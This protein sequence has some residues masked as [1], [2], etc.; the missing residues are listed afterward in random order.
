VPTLFSRKPAPAPAEETS[1]AAARPKG[2]TPSKKDLGHSTP[3]RTPYGKATAVKPANK[4]EAV[5]QLRTKQREARLKA[6]EDMLAGKEEALLPRDKG[7]ER[8]L[9]RNIVDARRNLGGYLMI[10][11]LLFFVAS[12]SRSPV[13]MNYAYLLW[14][15]YALVSV[16]D[17][18]LIARRI[19]AILPQRLPKST[20]R[21]WR[22]YFYGGMRA[23]TPRRM[24]MPAPQVKLGDKV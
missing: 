14:L 7:P 12:F 13:I 19:K 21:R 11:T 15:A 4:K 18:F 22:L 24:R 16:I 8:R 1:E 20:V 9:V 17:S 2:Y 6:R 5:R 3:K 23:M 10:V